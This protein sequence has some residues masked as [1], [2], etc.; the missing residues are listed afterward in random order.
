MVLA[1]GF[2]TVGYRNISSL[3]F[4]WLILMN[5]YW[6]AVW[7]GGEFSVQAAGGQVRNLSHPGGGREEVSDSKGTGYPK[8]CERGCEALEEKI[9]L[10][11]RGTMTLFLGWGCS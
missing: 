5:E 9:T 7:G 10:R 11:A 3:S 4:F 1:E 6:N 2:G 8:G